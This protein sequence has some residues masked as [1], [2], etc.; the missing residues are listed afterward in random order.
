MLIQHY[1]IFLCVCLTPASAF[2]N[3]H[4]SEVSAVIIELPLPQKISLILFP[5]HTSLCF[6]NPISWCQLAEA[7]EDKFFFFL[8]HPTHKLN[9][10]ANSPRQQFCIVTINVQHVPSWVL[11]ELHMQKGADRPVKCS[12]STPYPGLH[13][14]YKISSVRSEPESRLDIVA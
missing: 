9:Y 13:H 6:R 14:E 12:A 3:L 2:I 11:S 5:S 4:P 7:S 10:N 8:C 1:C